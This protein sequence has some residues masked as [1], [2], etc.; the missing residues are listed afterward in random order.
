MEKTIYYF[1]N[2]DKVITAIG[3]CNPSYMTERG[4]T[5]VTQEQYEEYITTNEEYLAKY[6]Q[7]ELEEGE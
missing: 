2:Y 5:L 6:P 1:I 4:Y 3:E 7:E